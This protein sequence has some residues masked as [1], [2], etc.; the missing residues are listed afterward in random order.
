[1]SGVHDQ[2]LRVRAVMR[3]R[4]SGGENQRVR[5]TAGAVAAARGDQRD[6]VKLFR[7]TRCWPRLRRHS[8]VLNGFTD[9]SVSRSAGMYGVRLSN[10]V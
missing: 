10:R 7:G 4:R 2:D 9:Q 3:T 5:A 6:G 1:M 8:R